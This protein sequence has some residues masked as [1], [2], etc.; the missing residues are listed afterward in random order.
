ML[1]EYGGGGGFGVAAIGGSSALAD[2]LKGK[3][4][5]LILHPNVKEPRFNVNPKTGEKFQNGY[6]VRAATAEEI[7]KWDRK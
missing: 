3:V 4:H 2:T 6:S 5:G 7:I 1:N